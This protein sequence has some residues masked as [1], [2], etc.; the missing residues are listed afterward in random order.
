MNIQLTRDTFT[1]NETLSTD[2][3]GNFAF[4][5][6]ER[7]D[8]GDQPGVSCVPMA[9]YELVPHISARLH[10]DDG[11]T[12][13]STWA[14]VNP[15][16]GVFHDEEDAIGYTGT[17]PVRTAVLI[18]PANFAHELLGCIAP[19]DSRLKMADG[20]WMVTNSRATFKKLR[21]ILGQGTTGHTITIT[22][23]VT[24]A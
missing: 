21:A 5:T 22:K 6:I 2:V 24:D 17:Y 3:L 10:E 16:V 9:E 14:L 15:A 8:S 1:A 7:P 12:P 19:G 4:D 20:T 23:A 13:L 18:H 11:V